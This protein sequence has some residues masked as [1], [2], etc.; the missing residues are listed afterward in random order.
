M[1]KQLSIA[2]SQDMVPSAKIVAYLITT[3]GQVVSDS[4]SFHVDSSGE[5]KVSNLQCH[6]VAIQDKCIRTFIG[7]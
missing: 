3:E 4:V 7:V 5:N 6:H 2:L 1:S